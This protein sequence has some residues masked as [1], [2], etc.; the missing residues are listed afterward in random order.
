VGTIAIGS[1]LIAF[2]T[3]LKIVLFIFTAEQKATSDDMNCAKKVLI[4]FLNCMAWVVEKI[5]QQF[6]RY[7]FIHSS[8]TGTNFCEAAW[9]SMCVNL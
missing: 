6:T 7:G 4:G 1:V 2:A 8:F 9:T 3:L 5:C